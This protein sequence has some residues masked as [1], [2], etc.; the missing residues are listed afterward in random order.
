[1]MCST[2]V[3]VVL[4]LHAKPSEHGLTGSDGSLKLEVLAAH[5]FGRDGLS[6]ESHM[7]YTNTYQGD[8]GNLHRESPRTSVLLVPNWILPVP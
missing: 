7:S 3:L 5:C 4:V 2:C 6:L 1:M 8:A